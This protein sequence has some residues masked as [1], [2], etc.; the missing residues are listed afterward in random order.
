MD[1]K[2]AEVVSDALLKQRI[3]AQHERQ[4][5][6]EAALEIKES[7]NV[8]ARFAATFAVVGINSGALTAYFSTYSFSDCMLA[9]G[10]IGIAVGWVIANWRYRAGRAK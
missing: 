7:H 8:K 4:Q 1:K 10:V 5:R 6:R 2:Q 9:G 3:D